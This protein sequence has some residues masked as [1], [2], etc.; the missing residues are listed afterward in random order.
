MCATI[1]AFHSMKSTVV[2]RSAVAPAIKNL[3][4]WG[5]THNDGF[6]LMP[7]KVEAYRAGDKPFEYSGTNGFMITFDI[8]SKDF[9]TKAAMK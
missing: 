5:A 4:Y 2:Q 6:V 9:T 7:N 1:V 8:A 3:Q